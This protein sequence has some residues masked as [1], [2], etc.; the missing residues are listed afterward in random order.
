MRELLLKTQQEV[1]E[2]NTKW[3]KVIDCIKEMDMSGFIKLDNDKMVSRVWKL[4]NDL[5]INIDR[6]EYKRRIDL[7]IKLAFNPDATIDIRDCS[8]FNEVL[9]KAEDE[10]D[11][12]Q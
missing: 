11:N 1:H 3:N 8:N 9:R 4:E 2:T 12:D 7:I 6:S 5:S 10:V